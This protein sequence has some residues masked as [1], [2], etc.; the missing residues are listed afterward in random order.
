MKAESYLRP[1]TIAK[2]RRLDLKAKFIVE[3]FFT[4]SHSSPFQGFS[5]EFSE[6]RKY[7][8]GDDIRTIDWSVYAKTDRFYVKKFRAETNMVCTLVV[9]TSA[10][11]GYRYGETV[12]KLEYAI[13]LAAALGYLMIHQQDTVGLVTVDEAIRTVLPHKSKRSHL[14]NVLGTLAATRPSESTGLGACLSQVA[15]LIHKRGLV[16]LLTDLLDDEDEVLKG[17]HHLKFYGHDII[18]FHVLHEAERNLPFEGQVRF[19][20]MET[21]ERLDADPV[22]LRRTYRREIES[23]I[24]RWRERCLGLGIDFVPLDTSIAY[25]EALTRFLANRARYGM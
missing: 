13:Y 24:E 25:D 17:L 6:H 2:V 4:G 15:N 23:F 9:D 11:M 12:S 22:A 20:D 21:G 3:G 10:S 8:P 14:V 7:V 5:T 19:R 16:V 18:L 1:E